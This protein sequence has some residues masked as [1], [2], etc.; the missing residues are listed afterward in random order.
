LRGTEISASRFARERV[1]FAP[2]PPVRAEHASPREAPRT[3]CCP[4]V[5]Y[6]AN[7]G[8]GGKDRKESERR[9]KERET[10]RENPLAQITRLGLL[11]IVGNF[12][13]HREG[14][15][16]RRSKDDL[17]A[18]RSR[19]RARERERERERETEA[20]IRRASTVQG[21]R[22][23]FLPASRGSNATAPRDDSRESRATISSR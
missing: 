7:E 20:R 22:L 23:K 11:F 5:L 14:A 13:F 9:G 16:D 15:S 10:G 19:I 3:T 21:S 18:E 12:C 8:E 1:I 6:T 2:V 4:R 17:C